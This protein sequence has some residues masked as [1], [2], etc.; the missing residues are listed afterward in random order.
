MHLYSGYEIKIDNLSPQLIISAIM[1]DM[2]NCKHHD[3][4]A[5]KSEMKELIQKVEKMIWRIY[6]MFGR[7]EVYDFF[8][9]YKK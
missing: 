8:I 1:L 5:E 9:S 2:E 4:H 3:K 6:E 7:N